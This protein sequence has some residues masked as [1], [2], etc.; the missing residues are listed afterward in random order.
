MSR[1]WVLSFLLCTGCQMSYYLHSAYYQTQLIQSRRPIENVLKNSSLTEPQKNKL[2]LVMDAKKFG[3]EQLGLKPTSNYT[4]YVQLSRP[5]VTYVV[6]AA[7]ANELKPYLWHFPLVGKVP[8]K[9][10]FNR[11]LADREARSLDPALYDTHVRGVAAYSTLG[12][13]QDS[14]LSSMLAYDDV[15]LVE[16]ILHEM[17]HTTVYYPDAV[18]FNERLAT[19]LGQEGMRLYF[20]SREGANS[21][22]VQEADRAARDQRLFSRFLSTEVEDLKKWYEVRGGSTPSPA[23]KTDRLKAIQERFTSR[24]QP[25]MVTKNYSGFAKVTLNNAVILGYRTYEY[26]LEE[27]AQLHKQLGQDFK[28]TLAFAQ[29]LKK[30]PDQGVREALSQSESLSR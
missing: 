22:H 5:Y 29:G 14:V 7:H 12:W 25:Q 17:V 16:L 20:Q 21:P 24:V 4:T 28:K 13:F 2:R 15:D 8:Y 10:Y 11:E 9:G 26:N 27:L 1:L 19:F 18:D 3:E 6:Q 23:E 30:H